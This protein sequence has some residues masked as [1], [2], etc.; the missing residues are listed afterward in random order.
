MPNT[1]ELTEEEIRQHIN[2]ILVNAK[3]Q[4]EEYLVSYVKAVANDW[5]KEYYEAFREDF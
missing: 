2:Y 3:S 4:A 1:E 5:G